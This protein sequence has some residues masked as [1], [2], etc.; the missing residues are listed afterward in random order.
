MSTSDQ[1][2]KIAPPR[3]DDVEKYYLK[4]PSEISPRCAWWLK[5]IEAGWVGNRRTG[6]NGYY[7]AAEYFGVYIS[8]YIQLIMPALAAKR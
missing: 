5:R 4:L 8:E 6:D 2:D 3:V 1:R 7:D